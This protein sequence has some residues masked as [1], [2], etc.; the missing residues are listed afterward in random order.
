MSQPFGVRLQ[1]FFQPQPPDLHARLVQ[2]RRPWV[3]RSWDGFRVPRPFARV[4][5]SYG[6]AVHVPAGLDEAG[7]E[8]WRLRLEEA[9]KANTERL[10]HEA[11]EDA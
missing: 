8:V 11:G 1:G 9:L 5:I 3:L 6:D 7:V 4:W 2:T 10:A